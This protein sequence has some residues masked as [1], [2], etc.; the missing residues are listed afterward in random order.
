LVLF[1]LQWS[2]EH[3]GSA[4][5]A[6]VS[7]TRGLRP[8]H[9]VVLQHLDYVDYPLSPRSNQL[10]PLDPKPA[11]SE[12][13][14][15]SNSRAVAPNGLAKDAHRMNGPSLSASLPHVMRILETTEGAKQ[16]P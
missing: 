8:L 6:A 14:R 15:N 4:A 2:A 12:M 3:R 10:I 1:V 9:L 11:I 13:K 16:L 7:D 5:K